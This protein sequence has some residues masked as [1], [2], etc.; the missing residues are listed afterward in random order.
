M[1]SDMLSL[2]SYQGIPKMLN[3]QMDCLDLEGTGVLVGLEMRMTL[4][5]CF[6]AFL[7]RAKNV[8]FP[9]AGTLKVGCHWEDLCNIL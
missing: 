1:V 7:G 8:K 3:R 5:Q 9:K 4:Q 2:R 6:S